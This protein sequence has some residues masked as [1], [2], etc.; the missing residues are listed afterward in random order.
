L[1]LDLGEGSGEFEV[2]MMVFEATAKCDDNDALGEAL[3]ADEE[4]DDDDVLGAKSW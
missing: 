4:G 3:V 1:G 2:G